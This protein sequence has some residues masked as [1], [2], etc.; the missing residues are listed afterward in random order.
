MEAL[1]YDAVVAHLARL[2]GK[3]VWI[4]ISQKGIGSLASFAAVLEEPFGPG[5]WQAKGSG[6]EPEP[7]TLKK[8][9][10]DYQEPYNREVLHLRFRGGVRVSVWER[11]DP[12][13]GDLQ[14][15][16]TPARS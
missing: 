11:R 5:F 13:D 15:F 4:G 14:R 7:D 8:G 3:P 6:F 1:D 12:T 10:L 9:L 2:T 16:V